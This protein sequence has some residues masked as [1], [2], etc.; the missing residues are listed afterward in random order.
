MANE[1]NTPSWGENESSAFV[2]GGNVFVPDRMRQHH[3]ICSLFPKV[4]SPFK[5]LDLCSGEGLLSFEIAKRSPHYEIY[6]YDGSPLMLENAKKHLRQLPNK[7]H[8]MHFD[9]PHFEKSEYPPDCG[10]VVSSLAIH[11]IE[12]NRKKDLFKFIYSILPSNGL[13]VMVDVIL[14]LC[15]EAARI[16]AEDWDIAAYKQSLDFT[17][18]FSVYNIFHEEK[19]NIYHYLDDKEYMAYDKPSTVYNHLKWLDEAGFSKVDV[20]WMYAGHVILYGIK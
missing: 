18:S 14:P 12:D 4:N 9:L 1:K 17:G 5:V 6:C 19:W 16:A 11:H 10:A 2:A 3:R 20:L 15:Q 13:F 7:S 8:F